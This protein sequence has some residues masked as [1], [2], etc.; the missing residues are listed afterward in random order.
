MTYNQVIKEIQT[1]LQSHPMLNTVKFATPSEWVNRDEQPVFPI[2]CFTIDRG[3]FNTGREQTYEIQIWFIDKS[4]VEGEF[5]EDV[6]SDMHQVSNDFVS[7]LRKGSNPYTIDDQVS[8]TAI[9]D[10]FDDYLSGITL[11]LNLSSMSEYGA[12]DF[13]IQPIISGVF[14]NSFDNTFN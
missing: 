1:I 12:C 10:K 7:Y 8:W 4:G 9:S 2:S 6:I 3:Q 11:T 14:D 5:I 13:P